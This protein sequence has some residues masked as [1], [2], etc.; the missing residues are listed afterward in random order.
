MF[1]KQVLLSGNVSFAE[2]GWL[3][4]CLQ[5]ED[6]GGGEEVGGE[7]FAASLCW[8]DGIVSDA[9]RIP[10]LLHGSSPPWVLGREGRGVTLTHSPG[11]PLSLGC[12]SHTISLSISLTGHLLIPP[13][14]NLARALSH[15]VFL[16][17]LLSETIFHPGLNY[18]LSL[19][20]QPLL[21]IAKSTAAQN[22]TPPTWSS[23]RLPLFCLS[24]LLMPSR[25]HALLSH[26]SVGSPGRS[27]RASRLAPLEDRHPLLC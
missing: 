18:S 15:L 10:A 6:W 7:G 14:P 3:A 1:S 9:G 21:L 16:F 12:Q 4:F 26:P 19:K 5:N 17:F 24:L 23:C 11:A 2:L 8:W 25:A 22:Y 27:S 20:R 13:C